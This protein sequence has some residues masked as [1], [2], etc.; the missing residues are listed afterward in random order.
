MYQIKP[1]QYINVD[2]I[3]KMDVNEEGIWRIVMAGGIT[4]PY[5]AHLG[6]Q[7]VEIE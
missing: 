3:V 6:D 5:A 7:D 2:Q 4:I 1:G